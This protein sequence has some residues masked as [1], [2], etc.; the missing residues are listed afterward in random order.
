M[1]ECRIIGIVSTVVLMLVSGGAMAQGIT[2]GDS[3]DDARL[4]R[5]GVMLEPF[6]SFTRETSEIKTSQ[7]P[8]ISDDT[9]GSSDAFGAGA[10]IGGHVWQTVFVGADGR[11]SKTQFHD[12]SYG[13]AAGWNYN[14]APVIGLQMPIAGLRVWG[15]YVVWGQY[16]PSAGRQ[17]FDAKF[18]SPTGPRVGVGFHLGPISLNLEYQDLRYD[19]TDVQSFGLINATSASNVDFVSRGY[20]AS[21]SFPVEL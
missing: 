15:E 17:G 2:T 20:A 11:F 4:S 10:R 13:N 3:S 19:R 21:V 7:L 18:R 14:L 1:K 8:I 16:D 6:V 5:S 12:S 9:S